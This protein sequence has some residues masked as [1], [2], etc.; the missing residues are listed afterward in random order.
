VKATAELALYFL[1]VFA[2]IGCLRKL[3]VIREII[4]LFNESRGPIWDLRQTINDLKGLEPIIHK[5][6][7][8]M[9]L[10]D[11]K[12][13][14]ARKQV[15][16]LQVESASE[17]TDE[18][19]E[20]VVAPASTDQRE[21]TP[22]EMANENWEKLRD[23][24]RRNTKRIEYVIEQIPDGRT[25]LA[26]DRMPRT[27]YRSIITKLQGAKVITPAAANASRELIELFNRYRPKNRKVPD[28]LIGPL[29]VLDKQLDQE[30]VDYAKVLAAE[31]SES[32]ES[33][34]PPQPRANGNGARTTNGVP[35]QPPSGTT[36]HEDRAT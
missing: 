13:D 35:S 3:S 22:A 20:F 30:L 26:Y 15:A 28:E 4:R 6:G 23:Y 12:V 14:A 9:A 29:E 16:V 18:A 1:A 27:G 7:N 10:L 19:E 25:R 24:W 21:Q 5:L 31:V 33:A 2:V 8:Q 34:P 17:R 11:E 36:L 32:A